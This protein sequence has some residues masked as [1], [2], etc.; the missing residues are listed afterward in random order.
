[1]PSPRVKRHPNPITFFSSGLA[2][3]HRAKPEGK[4]EKM[5]FYPQPRAALA[6]RLPGAI[7]RSPRWDFRLSR[8][9]RGVGPQRIRGLPPDR[10]TSRPTKQ[11]SFLIGNSPLETPARPAVGRFARLWVSTALSKCA[12]AKRLTFI[13]ERSL[14]SSFGGRAL[15]LKR[16]N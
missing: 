2:R 12:R 15:M 13:S 4:K 7:I 8:F 14:M 16:Q 1:M 9:A 3:R 10:G 6:P 5:I 11:T